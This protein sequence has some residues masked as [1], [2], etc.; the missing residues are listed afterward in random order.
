MTITHIPGK[1]NVVA[2]ILLRM[3]E[4]QSVGEPPPPTLAA[5][6]IRCFVGPARI[7]LDEWLDDYRRDPDI[8][9]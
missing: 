5:S 9:E 7:L 6:V 3:H 8:L 4:Q 2:D 1:S